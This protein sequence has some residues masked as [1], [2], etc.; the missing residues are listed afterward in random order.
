MGFIEM[1][2]ATSVE[3]IYISAMVLFLAFIYQVQIVFI[4]YVFKV[5]LQTWINFNFVG[6]K[7]ICMVHFMVEGFSGADRLPYPTSDFG[8]AAK[9][10][11]SGSDAEAFEIGFW[12][13][14]AFKTSKLF[15]KTSYYSKRVNSL[16]QNVLLFKS[17]YYP[18]HQNYFSCYWLL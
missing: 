13:W 5:L 3:Y 7:Q 4:F 2:V 14:P 9:M 17:C 15:F 12:H 11:F 16:I 8:S 10:I 18:K 6:T 1:F